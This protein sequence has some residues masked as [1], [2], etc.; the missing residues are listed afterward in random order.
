MATAGVKFDDGSG[1]FAANCFPVRTLFRQSDEAAGAWLV[2]HRAEQRRRFKA[3]LCTRPKTF[4]QIREERKKTEREN[5][6]VTN[7]NG[8]HP[9]DE[10][11]DD[12]VLDGFFLL[13]HCCVDD[14]SDLCS[15]NIAGQEMSDVKE[16][17]L[18]MFDNVAYVNAAENYLPLEAFNHFPIIRELEVP[19]NGLRGLKLEPGHFPYLEMLDLSYNNLSQEDI[20]SVGILQHL[21]VLQLSGNNF[22]SLPIDMTLPYRDEK[23][24]RARYPKLEVLMLDDNKLSDVSVFA[25]LAGLRCLR[26]LNLEKNELYFVPQ[27]MVLDGRVKTS[28][29]D[30]GSKQRKKSGRTG[31]PSSQPYHMDRIKE[32]LEQRLENTPR[33]PTEDNG[34][35]CGLDT[36][37]G[38][39]IGTE[40]D[41]GGDPVD[42]SP[43]TTQENSPPMKT[44]DSGEII[45]DEFDTSD[46]SARI[47][48]LDLD[49]EIRESKEDIAKAASS[50][51]LY[52]KPLG[53]PPPPFSELRYLNL[54]YNLFAHEEALLAVAAWPMLS[55]LIIHNNPLTDEHPG[56]PP[57]LKRFLEDRLGIK[58][59]RK[60]PVPPGKKH[61]EVSVKKSRKVKSTIPKI[62][63]VSVEER[64]M[65]EAPPPER[66][67]QSSPDNHK[68]LPPIHPTPEPRPLTADGLEVKGQTGSEDV[69]DES[70][71]NPF[72]MTQ[73]DDQVDD[74]KAVA[75]T[76]KAQEKQLAKL[77]QDER[78]KGYEELLDLDEDVDFEM[79]KDIPGNVRAL[80]YALGHQLVYRDAVPQLDVIKKRVKAYNRTGVQYNPGKSKQEK[81]EE[82]LT[83]L[84]TRQAVEE[85]NLASVLK[86]KKKMKK[87]FPEAEVLLDEIQRRYNMV[88]FASMQEAQNSRSVVKETLV[89]AQA[90]LAELAQSA[91]G[92]ETDGL[93]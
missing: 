76:Q 88:R 3:I 79:P 48:D 33:G 41:A 23:G 18:E 75:K 86:S 82:A 52:E 55:E 39:G 49:Q 68:P 21:R 12:F 26:Q 40:E 46:L 13:R 32:L 27:L 73:V 80:K 19:L 78:Y 54:G 31:R 7:R 59:V 56:D 25:C 91:K 24:R 1:G 57:L 35:S 89:E 83:N 60:K 69:Q 14:P 11:T 17:D 67:T 10:Q 43:L 53:P 71:D 29:E 8:K 6:R 34:A 20:L 2:A 70:T 30:L 81:I 38:N 93:N 5:R 62:P 50:V 16:E 66:Q 64:L 58:L 42:S 87:K 37:E 28:D 47:N 85:A 72:F 63:R 51:R 9:E 90:K 22:K 74:G 36:G 45:Y 65:L 4:S 61:I 77:L 84:K 92:T 44:E 15:I